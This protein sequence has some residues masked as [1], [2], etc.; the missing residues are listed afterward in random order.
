MEPMR[1]KRIGLVLGIVSAV[2]A[3]GALGVVELYFLGVRSQIRLRKR[4]GEATE[5]LGGSQSDTSALKTL[6]KRLRQLTNP[7]TRQPDNKTEE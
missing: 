6:E 7:G 5:K 2:I 1:K 3:A 4:L